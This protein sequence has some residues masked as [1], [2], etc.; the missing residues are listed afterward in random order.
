MTIN[1]ISAIELARD[2]SVFG[3]TDVIYYTGYVPPIPGVVCIAITKNHSKNATG[4]PGRV[5]VN[6]LNC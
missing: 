6:R 5:C 3:A 2:T 1:T 4:I